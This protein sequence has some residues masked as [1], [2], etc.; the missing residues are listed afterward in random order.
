MSV[1]RLTMTVIVDGKEEQREY[2]VSQELGMGHLRQC[3]GVMVRH[4]VLLPGERCLRA[5]LGHPIIVRDGLGV[6]PSR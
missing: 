4:P 1:D 2:Y 5:V 3:I 6:G